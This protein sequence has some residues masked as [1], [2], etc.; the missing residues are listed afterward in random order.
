MLKDKTVSED[1]ERKA[2]AEIQKTTDVHV[3]LIDDF[4]KKKDTEL[5]GK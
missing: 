2:E 4:Q 3:S 5:L 1:D